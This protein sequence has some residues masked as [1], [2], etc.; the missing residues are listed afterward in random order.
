MSGKCGHLKKQNRC[1][2]NVKK[3]I[4]YFFMDCLKMADENRKNLILNVFFVNF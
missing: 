3:R 4:R 2:S 1:I